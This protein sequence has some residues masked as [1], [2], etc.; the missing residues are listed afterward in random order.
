MVMKRAILGVSCLALLAPMV[1]RGQQRAEVRAAEES[2]RQQLRV[3]VMAMTVAP[4]VTV[5][6]IADRRASTVA[7]EEIV[8]GAEQ[9]GSPRWVESDVV[10]VK[11]QVPA[12]AEIVLESEGAY[13]LFL[14]RV[15]EGVRPWQAMSAF[16]PYK[17]SSRPAWFSVD[18]VHAVL[19]KVVEDPT[20]P[21]M[22]VSAARE[23][24]D[25]LA[26]SL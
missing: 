20:T 10:Q 9:I 26:R 19:T 15:S 7:I 25:T 11:L 4:G 14:R 24:L 8:A 13:R 6:S 22:A 23:S 12:S 17:A 3:A 21:P 18:D 16:C 5:R 1:A 2:A